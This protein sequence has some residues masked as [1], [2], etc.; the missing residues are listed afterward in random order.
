MAK[1]KKDQEAQK[2]EPIIK[3]EKPEV[4]EV[5]QQ[6]NKK[7]FP[8]IVANNGSH[9]ETK[10]VKTEDKKEPLM[11]KVD[12]N[13]LVIIILIQFLQPLEYEPDKDKFATVSDMFSEVPTVAVEVGIYF[14]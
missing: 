4:K 10:A 5:M 2:E 3:E 12:S 8:S 7:D 1:Y 6:E 9:Q 14:V 13:S 11:K